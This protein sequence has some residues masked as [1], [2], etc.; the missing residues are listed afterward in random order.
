MV[1]VV[2]VFSGVGVVIGVGVIEMVFVVE[3][4]TGVGVGLVIDVVVSEVGEFHI[5]KP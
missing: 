3:V 1:S 4:I 2:E 5:I